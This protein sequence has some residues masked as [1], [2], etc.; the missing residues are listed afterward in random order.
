M[1][2]CGV[3]SVMIKFSLFI[4]TEGVQTVAYLPHCINYDVLLG[5]KVVR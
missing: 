2:I 1:S 4:E 5:Y 3:L